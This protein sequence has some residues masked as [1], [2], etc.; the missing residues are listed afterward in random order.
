MRAC[1]YVR[2]CVSTCDRSCERQEQTSDNGWPFFHKNKSTRIGK[3][4]GGGGGEMNSNPNS[5]A[6]T[7]SRCSVKQTRQI[8]RQRLQILAP[9]FP[10]HAITLP[11]AAGTPS[12]SKETWKMHIPVSFHTRLKYW[13]STNISFG[14]I[15]LDVSICMKETIIAQQR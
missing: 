12:R 3:R 15:F 11:Y 8:R 7:G 1:V 2:A 4:G 10:S 6:Q 9:F 13:M 14:I 5:A